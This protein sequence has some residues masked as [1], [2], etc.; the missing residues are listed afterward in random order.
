MRSRSMVIILIIILFLFAGCTNP[1][2]QYNQSCRTL[3]SSNLSPIATLITPSLNANE[4]D[5]S[6]NLPDSCNNTRFEDVFRTTRT[7]TIIRG[8]GAVIEENMTY[9]VQE[10]G[11]DLKLPGYVPDDFFFRYVIVPDQHSE[12]KVT[13]TFVNKSSLGPFV[14]WSSANQME[15]VFSRNLDVNF[16]DFANKEPEAVCIRGTPGFF[17]S[18]SGLN[19]LRW[20]DGDVERWIAGYFNEETL[21]RMAES[22]KCPSELDLTSDV[23]SGNKTWVP[24]TFPPGMTVPATPQL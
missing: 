7:E 6:T 23:Y 3:T 9:A 13:L 2:G 14:T 19:R 16:A 8:K 24:G 20:L 15:I 10:F 17:Y 11:S 22:M 12:G 5:Q 21:I 18:D 1:E 4:S